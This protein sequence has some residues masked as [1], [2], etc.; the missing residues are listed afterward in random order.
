MK[1]PPF[2]IRWFKKKIDQKHANCLIYALYMQEM[3]GGQIVLQKT[4]RNKISWIVWWHVKWK[5][6]VCPYEGVCPGEMAFEPIDGPDVIFPP[7]LFT[8]EIIKGGFMQI[9]A[10]KRHPLIRPIGNGLAIT[11]EET[12]YEFMQRGKQYRLTVEKHFIYDGA[13]IPRIAW[14]V[15]GLTPHGD[16]DGP[17]LA[18]DFGYHYR[19]KFPKGSW[20]FLD[21]DNVWKE[22]PERMSRK[23]CDDLIRALCLH[24]KIANGLQAYLVWKAVR[25]FAGVAWKRNDPSRKLLL[26]E[27]VELGACHQ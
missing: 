27:H 16:M 19:G 18:H 12:V 2:V 14:T 4:V 17:G 15:L 20:E 5:P 7:I 10:P 6:S 26:L 8:G 25:V 23:M 9:L 21:V 22:C 3:Y 11:E 24:F 13:S 1:L